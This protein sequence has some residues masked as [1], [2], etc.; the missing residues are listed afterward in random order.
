MVTIR[1]LHNGLPPDNITEITQQADNNVPKTRRQQSILIIIPK[2]AHNS[3]EK[4]HWMSFLNCHNNLPWEWIMV[5]N[6]N[7]FKKKL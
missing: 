7:C 4:K 1:K 5:A 6:L 2:F 3:Y